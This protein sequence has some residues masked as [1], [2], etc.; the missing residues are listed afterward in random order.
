M[1]SIIHKTITVS[2]L[3]SPAKQSFGNFVKAVI[4]INKKIIAIGGNLHADEEAELIKNGSKQE[5]LWGINIYPELSNPDRIEFDS[6]INIRPSIGNMSRGV[7]NPSI[8]EQI[9]SIVN[10]LIIE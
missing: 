8:Q 2:E 6:M 5:N 9:R 4:D 1:I 7:D 10:K 3:K